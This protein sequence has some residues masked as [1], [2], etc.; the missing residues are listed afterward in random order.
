[1]RDT[2][3]YFPPG[4]GE[5]VWIGGFG[6]IYKVPGEATGGAVAIVKPS[7]NGEG[8]DRRGGWHDREAALTLSRQ[9]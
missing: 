8:G 6:T 4:A 1:M 7:S 2:S 5:A 3:T 9:G